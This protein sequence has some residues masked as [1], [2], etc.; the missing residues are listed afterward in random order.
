MGSTALTS[1]A[2]SELSVN[3][4]AGRGRAK[5]R[6]RLQRAVGHLRIAGPED[7]MRRD[8]GAGPGPE[9]RLN[10]DL[11]QRAEPMRDSGSRVGRST[12]SKPAFARVRARVQG[13]RFPSVGQGFGPPDH[14]IRES[15]GYFWNT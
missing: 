4:V 14:P 7:V 12:A 2:S 13:I 10:V 8:L 5:P 9:R 11:G 3:H 1:G 15:P 6:L